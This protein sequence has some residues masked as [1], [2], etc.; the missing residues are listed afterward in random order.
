[1]EPLLGRE[2]QFGRVGSGSKWTH[3]QEEEARMAT[4]IYFTTN[5]WEPGV[6]PVFVSTNQWEQGVVDVTPTQNQ[7]EAGVMKGFVTDNQYE[8]GVIKI[9]LS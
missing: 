6:V 2:A 1:M 4:P 7:Y 5:R 9:R 8:P 3:R